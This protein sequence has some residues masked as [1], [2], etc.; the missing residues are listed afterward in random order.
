MGRKYKGG[1]LKKKGIE[2]TYWKLAE[3]V[4]TKK[5]GEILYTKSG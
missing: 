1:V 3:E 5:N 4:A 2:E